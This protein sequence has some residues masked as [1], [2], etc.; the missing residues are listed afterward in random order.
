MCLPHL[1]SLTLP[2]S[3]DNRLLD[4]LL[5]GAHF[6]ALKYLW[7]GGN[8]HSLL[9]SA[10]F[11]LPSIEEVRAY[12][13]DNSESYEQAQKALPLPEGRQLHSSP[14][15]H[16]RL[17]C[18]DTNERIAGLLLW[19]K[20]L[21][22]FSSSLVIVGGFSPGGVSRAIQPLSDHLVELS[23]TAGPDE[24]SSADGTF[25]TFQDFHCL[26]KL[27]TSACLIFPGDNYWP[28]RAGLYR[29]FPKSLVELEVGY[30]CFSGRK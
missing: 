24:Y 12:L 19:P 26:R 7:L 6:Q 14:V 21:E 13:S 10:M 1:Q 30:L 28:S 15:K 18:F 16:L 3:F 8:V 2:S 20:C 27:E 5:S 11:F 22:S 25:M 17:S 29:Q 9:A 23:L 4:P